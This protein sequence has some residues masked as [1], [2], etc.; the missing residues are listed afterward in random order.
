MTELLVGRDAVET[1]CVVR[2]TRRRQAQKVVE[3]VGAAARLV[4]AHGCIT[5]SVLMRELGINHSEA[6]YALRLLQ[7]QSRVVEVVVAGKMA[8]WCRDSAAAEELLRRLRESVH[9]LAVEN[10]MRYATPKKILQAA[11][12]DRDAYEL[13]SAFIPL[14][15]HE[16]KFHPMALAIIRDILQQ[17][18]G[19]PLKYSNH[20]Y[21]YIVTP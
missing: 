16:T 1:Y 20:K 18:Y 14:S 6:F 11:L 5:T 12:R 2:R 15:R 7:M 10:G 17:L 4:E 9:R 3:R 19:K 13:L 21:V 8:V